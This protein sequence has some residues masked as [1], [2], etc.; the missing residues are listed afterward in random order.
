MTKCHSSVLS[1]EEAKKKK[2]AYVLDNGLLMHRWTSDIS[3]D[4]DWRVTYQVVVPTTYR[5]QV[6][7]LAHDH[8]WWVLKHFFWPGLK[9][10]VVHHCHT[11][12]VCKVAGKPNQVISPAPLCPIPVKGEP[13]ERVIVD[14]VGL[15]PK[16]RAGN[17]F[18][19]TVIC[20]STRFPDA[21]PLQKI[22][23]SVITKALVNFFSMF[24]LPGVPRFQSCWTSV[25]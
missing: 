7:S 13:F 22:T 6:L 2:I 3:E 18:L 9:S 25:G 20:A 11:C 17:Q 24:G 8:P 19:L 21:I 5:S 4:V 15:L 23:A 16:T 1:Q 12:H 10:D 14:C